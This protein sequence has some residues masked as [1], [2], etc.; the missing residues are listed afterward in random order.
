MAGKAVSVTTIDRI[1]AALAAIEERPLID[2]L[3]P[4]RLEEILKREQDERKAVLER[5]RDG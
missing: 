3:L 5:L 4:E 1:A 2:D